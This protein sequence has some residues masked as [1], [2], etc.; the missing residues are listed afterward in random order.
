MIRLN[1]FFRSEYHRLV[2]FV[3]SRI[4][5]TAD[6]DAEDIVQDVMLNLFDKADMGAPIENL[7][8]YIY[9][10]LRNRI[11]DAYR[12]RRDPGTLAELVRGASEDAADMLERKR[13][14]EDI[15]R[16]VDSL[17]EDQRAIVIATE[18]E[19]RGF[20]ELSEE[21]GVPIGTLLARKSRALRRIRDNL[22][23]PGR[24]YEEK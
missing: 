6:R 14:R 5:E 22:T 10:A 23:G 3:R 15:Y 18:F 2:R 12:R 13:L 16:A 8:A 1:E 24:L 17:S 9:Q 20:R 4:D 19:G 11:T 7:T 21:W